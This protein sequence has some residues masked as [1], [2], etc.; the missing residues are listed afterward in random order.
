MRLLA[1]RRLV[2]PVLAACLVSCTHAA[3]P[4]VP[5]A[6]DPPAAPDV[7]ATT[8]DFNVLGSRDA[9][10]TMLEF[11]DLQCPYCAQFSLHTFPRLKQAYIDT[12]KVRYL[13]H[14]LPLAIHPHAIPAALAARCAGEQGRYWE[15]RHGVFD[16]QA[17]LNADIWDEL[18]RQLGLDVDR[19]AACR[20]DGR[21]FQAVHADAQLAASYD[22]ASTPSFVIGRASND[23]VVGKTVSGAQPFETYAARIDAFLAEQK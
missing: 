7:T 13:S 10:V 6:S 11:S 21:Q 14:E 4:D 9:P 15:Y 8:T 23:R 1:V 22:L 17:R 12:G 20:R 3:A 19:F 5:A 18:A 16:A 2:Y